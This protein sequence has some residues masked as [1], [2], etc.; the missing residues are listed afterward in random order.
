MAVCSLTS[1][2]TCIS[3]SLTTA[4]RVAASQRGDKLFTLIK[5]NSFIRKKGEGHFGPKFFL[6]QNLLQRISY[7]PLNVGQTLLCRGW[8]KDEEQSPKNKTV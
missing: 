8:C 6:I 7:R 3:D 2:Q 1:K 5:F 4:G